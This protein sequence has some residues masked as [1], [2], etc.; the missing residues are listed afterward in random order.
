MT[1]NSGDFS[2]VSV[3]ENDTTSECKSRVALNRILKEKNLHDAWRC[4]YRCE[5]KFMFYRNVSLSCSR[6]DLFFHQPDLC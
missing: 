5:N 2:V 6:T 4:F 1:I 3:P